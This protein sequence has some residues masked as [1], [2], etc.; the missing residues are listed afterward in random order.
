LSSETGVDDNLQVL[1]AVTDGI[2]DGSG[3]NYEDI[4][5]RPYSLDHLPDG[6]EMIGRVR[7]KC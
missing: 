3:F 7:E 1:C 2:K 6:A 5:L 4:L